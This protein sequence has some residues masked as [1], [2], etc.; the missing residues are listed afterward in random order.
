MVTIDQEDP[1]AVDILSMSRNIWVVLIHRI[2]AFRSARSELFLGTLLVSDEGMVR[3]AARQLM[4]DWSRI[5]EIEAQ[6][7]SQDLREALRKKTDRTHAV[8][9]RTLALEGLFDLGDKRAWLV[10]SY[11]LESEDA[12]LRKAAEELARQVQV[13]K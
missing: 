7:A 13:G 9:V 12:A 10:L 1:T 3:E 4:D 5:A 8:I 11:W 2:R 6:S